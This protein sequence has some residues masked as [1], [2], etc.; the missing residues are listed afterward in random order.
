M[1]VLGIILVH[2]EIELKLA[3]MPFSINLIKMNHFVSKIKNWG[4]ILSSM[5][6]LK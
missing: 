5:S 4:K 1:N 2:L 6:C 3:L